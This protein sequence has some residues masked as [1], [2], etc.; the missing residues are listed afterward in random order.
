[1]HI[2]STLV[3]V[4][5]IQLICAIPYLLL[6]SLCMG[7]L[8]LPFTLSLWFVSVTCCSPLLNIEPGILTKQQVTQVFNW[9]KETLPLQSAN[10]IS[11]HWCGSQYKVCCYSYVTCLS[12][13]QDGQF[14]RPVLPSN[15]LAESHTG[16]ENKVNSVEANTKKK[17]LCQYTSWIKIHCMWLAGCS[18]RC[19]GG[20]SVSAEV[21]GLYNNNMDVNEILKCVW[22]IYSTL[23]WTAVASSPTFQ[24]LN[25]RKD[26]FIFITP[27]A[28][29]S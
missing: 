12:G 27:Q 28:G 22:G 13:C 9:T 8:S 1:M 18:R 7:A 3:G 20:C 10:Y 11:P 17:I 19:G 2:C 26:N 25:H 6:Q 24:G 21:K 16:T 23:S 15:Q 29:Y 5:A 14:H 4:T